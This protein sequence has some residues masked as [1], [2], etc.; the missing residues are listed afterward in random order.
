MIA[1][2][3]VKDVVNIA[4]L[5]KRFV[6]TFQSGK[7]I[8]A[9]INISNDKLINS[10]L[11]IAHLSVSKEYYATFVLALSECGTL[12]NSDSF[13][14]SIFNLLVSFENDSELV[15]FFTALHLSLIHI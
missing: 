3:D 5:G 12:T 1:H 2:F 10:V 6:L 14:D 4:R 11:E 9:N 13:F 8:L 7:Q 15:S